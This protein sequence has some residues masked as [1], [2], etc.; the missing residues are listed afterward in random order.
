MPEL[1]PLKDMARALAEKAEGFPT[2]PRKTPAGGAVHVPI[3]DV[4][5]NPDICWCGQPNGHDWTLKDLGAPH[6]RYPD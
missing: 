6:P 5:A 2:P 3:E 4:I 1:D